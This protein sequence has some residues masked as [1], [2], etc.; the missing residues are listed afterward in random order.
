MN[1]EASYNIVFNI[2]QNSLMRYN[3]GHIDF[4]C[5]LTFTYSHSELEAYV[6]KLNDDLCDGLRGIKEKT[7]SEFL[8]P[9]KA[10]AL[11][12]LLLSESADKVN[13]LGI[14]NIKSQRPD[15]FDKYRKRIVHHIISDYFY[16]RIVDGKDLLESKKI[17]YRKLFDVLISTIEKGYMPGGN[18]DKKDYIK[19]F[20]IIESLIKELISEINTHQK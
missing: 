20:Y 5:D 16:Y 8:Q 17:E 14:T 4:Q 9:S 12:Y 1:N 11:L 19:N 6:G 7:G 2:I 18:F 13:F 15:D 3:E 10:I